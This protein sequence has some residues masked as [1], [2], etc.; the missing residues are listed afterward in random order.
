MDIGYEYA[1]IIKTSIFTA[2][3]APLQPIIVIFAPVGL[4]LYYLI[5]KRNIFRHFQ[6]PSYHQASINR[7]VDMILLLSPIAFGFGQLTVFNFI[8]DN[9]EDIERLQ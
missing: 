4:V 6:R 8:P 2:F 7:V 1:Y 9:N 3:F 5:N